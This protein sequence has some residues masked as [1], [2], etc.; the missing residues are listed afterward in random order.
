MRKVLDDVLFKHRE[1][2]S[3]YGEKFVPACTNAITLA[4]SA[5][6]ERPFRP[7]NALNA[8]VF[9]SEMIGLAERLKENKEPDIKKIGEAYDTLL[10][11]AD[12]QN[13]YARATAD[14]ESVKSR[15]TLATKDR[16]SVVEGTSVSEREGPGGR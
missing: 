13:A 1:L 4:H 8:A 5:F 6:K 16:K 10:L 2:G 14:E 15:L 11:R 7:A 12:Y 3:K 9:D